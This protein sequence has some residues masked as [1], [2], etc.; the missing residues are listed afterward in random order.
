MT[1]IKKPGSRGS[2]Y[3]S[4]RKRIIPKAFRIT[5]NSTASQVMEETNG[6]STH[7]LPMLSQYI[8][9]FDSDL[10]IKRSLRAV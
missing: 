5:E 8:I 7:D 4:T 2:S 9:V 10:D 3:A 1:S 6:I